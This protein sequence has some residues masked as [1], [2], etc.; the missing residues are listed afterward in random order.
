MATPDEFRLAQLVCS[1]LCHDLAGLTG[2]IANGADLIGAS[3]PDPEAIGLIGASARQANAR[4]AFFR[5]AFG[6]STAAQSLAECL[7]LAGDVLASG[8]VRLAVAASPALQ[9]KLSPDGVR[10]CLTLVLAAAGCLPRGGTLGVE[11][12][13]LPDGVGVVVSANGAGAALKA[14]LAAALGAASPGGLSPREVHGY[15][16]GALARTDGGRVE[17][18][19][20]T[21]VVRLAAL[22]RKS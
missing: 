22:V 3:A 21:D 11:A 15:W 16:A 10:Q 6:A 5:I 12:A 1:R 4:I 18:E 7:P 14:E 17:V 13:D 20:G 9:I 8:P 2:A 19:G